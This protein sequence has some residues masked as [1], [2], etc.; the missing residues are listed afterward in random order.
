MKNKKGFTL[1]ELLAVIVILA[2]VTLIGATTVLPYIRNT[3]EQA[4]IVEI[5][6][7]INSA[8]KAMNLISLGKIDR[9]TY[10]LET[11]QKPNEIYWC[12]SLEDLVTLGL[13]TKD[14]GAVSG[15]TKTYDG[16]VRVRED[17]NGIYFYTVGMK[18]GEYYVK[19]ALQPEIEDS[20]KKGD[21]SICN[22]NLLQPCDAGNENSGN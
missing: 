5:N 9:A 10:Q 11:A 17:E 20:I 1:I 4:F 21:E 14:S 16:W 6:E 18:N 12:F 19:S 2:I 8:E 7:A 3:R 15:D 22:C 13:W